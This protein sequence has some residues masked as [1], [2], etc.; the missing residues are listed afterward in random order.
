MKKTESAGGVV[1]N[2]RGEVA[3][4]SQHGNSWSLPKGHVDLGEDVLTAA[5]REITEETGLTRLTLVKAFAPYTRY[6]GTPAGGDDTSELKTIYLF[7]FTTD[8]ETLAPQDPHNPEA[9]WVPPAE[10][11][12]LLTH[13]KDKAFFRDVDF[14]SAL[15]PKANVMTEL[16]AT[17]MIPTRS[18]IH[19]PSSS[20]APIEY[21]QK[22]AQAGNIM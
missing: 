9:R 12:A 13:P 2:A 7:L 4:V 5:Q 17:R 10:V 11:A 8:E 20:A 6:R 16:S 1:V 15:Q 19:L 22:I 18:H 3:V 14:S 21:M